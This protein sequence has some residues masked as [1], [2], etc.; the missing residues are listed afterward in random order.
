MSDNRESWKGTRRRFVERAVETGTGLG[1]VLT[2]GLVVGGI[3]KASEEVQ[4]NRALRYQEA[5]LE[6]RSREFDGV[7]EVTLDFLGEFFSVDDVIPAPNTSLLVQDSNP[8]D[9]RY[10][11]TFYI[12]TDDAYR[13]LLEY[14]DDGKNKRFIFP[15][16]YDNVRFYKEFNLAYDVKKAGD[17]FRTAPEDVA[18][19]QVLEMVFSTRG[20]DMDAASLDSLLSGGFQVLYTEGVASYITGGSL[21]IREIHDGSQRLYTVP[22]FAT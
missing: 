16:F 20:F 2:G 14:E 9:D 18:D 4:H 10:K 7:P 1:L 11:K 22:P 15:D 17:V 3:S 19:R 12:F 13:G 5:F 8:T 21:G 6:L